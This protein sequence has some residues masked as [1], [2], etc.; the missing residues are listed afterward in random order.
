MSCLEE[1]LVGPLSIPEYVPAPHA[2]QITDKNGV[3]TLLPRE[4]VLAVE[5]MATDLYD[6]CRIILRGADYTIEGG[7]ARKVYEALV[8][9]IGP[10][11]EVQE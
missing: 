6:K 1:S 4:K 3:K 9:F 5:F 7:S 2:I 10:I 11:V 8:E